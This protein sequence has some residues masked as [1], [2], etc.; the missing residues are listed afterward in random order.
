MRSWVLIVLCR[1]AIEET[2]EGS[3]SQIIVNP[4]RTLGIL[5]ASIK[6]DYRRF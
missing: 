2:V 1:Y 3:V 6:W 4:L 5:F